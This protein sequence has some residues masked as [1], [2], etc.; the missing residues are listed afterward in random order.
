M[1]RYLF[2]DKTLRGM[3][4]NRPTPFE[5]IHAVLLAGDVIVNRKTLEKHMR[6]SEIPSDAKYFLKIR[7]GFEDIYKPIE[8]VT[9]EG[10]IQLLKDNGQEQ[11]LFYEVEDQ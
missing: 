4:A 7:K 5:I 2:K 10:I 11:A 6:K 8:E 9:P 3:Q 1:K